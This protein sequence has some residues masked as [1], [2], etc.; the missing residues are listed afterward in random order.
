MYGFAGYLFL[1]G[2]KI[3]NGTVSVSPVPMLYIPLVLNILTICIAITFKKM[4]GKTGGILLLFAGILQM[5]F[6]V[7]S[8]TQMTNV[9]Q[10][11]KRLSP[12][13]VDSSRNARSLDHYQSRAHPLSQQISKCSGFYDFTGRTLSFDK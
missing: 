11:A 3:M 10:G 13:S 4:K 8:A 1:T 6:A 9:M 5:G 12:P 7:L 2:A